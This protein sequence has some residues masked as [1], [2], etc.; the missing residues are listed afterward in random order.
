M[1]DREQ[2]LARLRWR[3]RRG[4]R[5]LDAVLQAF[6]A[7]ES[8]TLTDADLTHF[9]AI[10]DLPDPVLFAYLTGRNAPDGSAF[11]AL[12]HRIRSCHIA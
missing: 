2:R 5:E 7:R 9:E 1:S 6:L 10:V 4:M 12:I 8:G 3:A 11:A